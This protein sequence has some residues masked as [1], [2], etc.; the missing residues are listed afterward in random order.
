MRRFDWWEDLRVRHEAL[1]TAF[2]VHL[3][4]ED[5]RSGESAQEVLTHASA[6]ERD[7]PREV[8]ELVANP[9]ADPELARQR[10]EQRGW[11]LHWR[12][13]AREPALAETRARHLTPLGFGKLGALRTDGA[14]LSAASMPMKLMGVLGEL[15]LGRP[16]HFAT[17]GFAQ[18]GRFVL[19]QNGR[20]FVITERGQPVVDT[21]GMEA[22]GLPPYRLSPLMLDGESLLLHA[23]DPEPDNRHPEL[24]ALL[25]ASFRLRL[26]FDGGF[27]GMCPMEVS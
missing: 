8:L 22:W 15:E 12:S 21:F 5:R 26:G 3:S 4:A 25:G 10:A 13:V 9:E 1:V 23:T 14:M 19:E 17:R 24:T 2:G 7:L 11:L 20:V 18:K 16:R 27:S 6:L